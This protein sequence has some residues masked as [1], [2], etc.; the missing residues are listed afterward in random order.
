M[1]AAE[2]DLI[3]GGLGAEQKQVHR[4][5]QLIAKAVGAAALIETPA[6]EQAAGQRL[7]RRP[8]GDVMGERTVRC[9]RL[10]AADRASPVRL[11]IA[12]GGLGSAPPQERPQLPERRRADDED[13]APFHREGRAEAGGHTRAGEGIEL[14]AVCRIS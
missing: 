3:A 13:G 12:Q 9:P 4:V 2:K 6:R 11:R 14:P 8:A 10:E 5:L 1:R 7:I